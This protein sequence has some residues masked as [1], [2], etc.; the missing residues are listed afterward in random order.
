MSMDDLLE[1]KITIRE[2][3]N[4]GIISAKILSDFDIWTR[5]NTVIEKDEVIKTHAVEIVARKCNVNE[6]TVWRSY[7]ATSKIMKVI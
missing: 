6:I 2:G 1:R 5:V 3:L 7:S 4:M